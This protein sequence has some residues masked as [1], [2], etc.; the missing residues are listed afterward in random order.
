MWGH[1]KI[2]EF[3]IFLKKRKRKHKRVVLELTVYRGGKQVRGVRVDKSKE[4]QG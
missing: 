4:K 1:V 3:S 2:G